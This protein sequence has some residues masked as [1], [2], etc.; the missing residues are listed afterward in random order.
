M[1]QGGGG[2][3]VICYTFLL[4]SRGDKNQTKTIKA[5]ISESKSREK[6]SIMRT[7]GISNGIRW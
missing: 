2:R 6:K 7:D 3:V 5:M 4:Y 1:L